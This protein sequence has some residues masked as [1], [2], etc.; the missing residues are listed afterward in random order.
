MINESPSNQFMQALVGRWSGHGDGSY[1]GIAP[2]RYV[3][4]TLIEMAPDWSM[5]HV[6]QRTWEREGD[7]GK[8]R[9]LHLEAGLIRSRDDGTL[10]YGCAQDSGRTE[11]MTGTPAL[12][13]GGVFHISWRT[14]EHANDDRLVELG[15]QWWL[16]R[17]TFIY[18]A[19]LSTIR[20][21][22]YRQHLDAR[23]SRGG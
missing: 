16:D 14:I 23:L 1:P 4:E 11:V 8:G 19:F 22:E 17:D 18:K 5:L 9:A 6:L 20:T 3:E 15:R 21:P 7:S 2:F 10:L 13:S 12:A